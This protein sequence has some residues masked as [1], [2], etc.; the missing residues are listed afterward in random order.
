[1]KKVKPV[2]EGMKGTEKEGKKVMEEIIEE[3][4]K[5]KQDKVRRERRNK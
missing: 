1:M 2:N 5:G 4:Q 3:R